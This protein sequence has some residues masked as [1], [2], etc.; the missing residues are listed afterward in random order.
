MTSPKSGDSWFDATA[1]RNIV[2]LRLTCDSRHP[3][4]K[5]WE[6]LCAHPSGKVQVIQYSESLVRGWY[7]APGIRDGVGVLSI[8]IW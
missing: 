2:L 6:C 7:K 8:D 1:K 3:E 5:Y 4:W